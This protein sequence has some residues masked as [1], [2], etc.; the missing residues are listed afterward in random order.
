VPERV[1]LK[2]WMD[3]VGMK[4]IVQRDNCKSEPALIAQIPESQKILNELCSSQ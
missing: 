2:N 1:Q 4:T 3:E